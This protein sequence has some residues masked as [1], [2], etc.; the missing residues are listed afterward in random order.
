M[1]CAGLILQEFA[2]PTH[3]SGK[4]CDIKEEQCKEEQE[5]VALANC[6]RMGFHTFTVLC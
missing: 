2:S 4:Y 5:K 1:G 3:N 6:L